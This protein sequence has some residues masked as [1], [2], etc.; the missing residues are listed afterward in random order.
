MPPYLGFTFLIKIDLWYTLGQNFTYILLIYIRYL[1]YLVS[2]YISRC[3][4]NLQKGTICRNFSRDS[5]IGNFIKL[6]NGF[7]GYGLSLAKSKPLNYSC[8]IILAE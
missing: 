6:A 3:C 8:N 4:Y 2:N 5:K 7:Q 1:K